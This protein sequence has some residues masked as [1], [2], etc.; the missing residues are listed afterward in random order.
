MLEREPL[1]DALK[2]GF[3]FQLHEGEICLLVNDDHQVAVSCAHKQEAALVARDM[4]MLLRTE[5][6]VCG[7]AEAV[8]NDATDRGR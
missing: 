3:C 1:G 4:E 5:F 8:F 6:H 2:K 7:E